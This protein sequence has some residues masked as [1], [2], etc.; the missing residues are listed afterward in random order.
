MAKTILVVEDNELLLKLY[1]TCL[2]S[3]GCRIVQARTGADALALARAH[4]PDL[5]I[6]DILLPDASG[7]EVTRTLKDEDELKDT[8]VIAVTTQAAAGDDARIRAAGCDAYLSKPI[9]V[10]SFLDTVGRFLG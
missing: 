6:M 2:S 7:L 9:N 4:R 3:L 10:Q 5:V 8:P 1:R